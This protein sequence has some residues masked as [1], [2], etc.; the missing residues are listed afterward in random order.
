MTHF[1]YASTTDADM[2]YLAGKRIADPFFYI[3]TDKTK[4]V[5]LNNLEI[6]AFREQGS[7]EVTALPLEPFL[8]D[9][10]SIKGNEP[11]SHALAL[12]V[13]KKYGLT[14][15]PVTVSK[16]FPLDMADYL[17][18]HGATLA[19]ADPFLPER[20][21]KT[22]HEVASIRESVKRT[23]AA[24]MRIEEILF[25]G[26]IA[27]DEILY[28]GVPLT[29]EFLKRE[30]E[31]VF[32]DVGMENSEGIIISSGKQAAMPHHEGSGVI[33]PH[34]TI[35]CDIFPRSKETGLPERLPERSSQ[36]GRS[37]SGYFADVTRTYIKG[38]SSPELE[39]MYAA[40]KD[41]QDA[42]FAV[43][44][45]GV[46]AEAVYDAAAKSITDAGFHA[47]GAVGFIHGLGH[48]VGLEVHE[49]P[50]VGA[51]STDILHAGNVITVEPGLYYPALGGVRLEDTVLITETG[52]ENLT[53]YPREFLIV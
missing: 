17:R 42:A 31:R 47:G 9:A 51:H 5:I 53:D 13:L 11:L 40:V 1:H 38:A 52:Y 44:R 37:Q 22:K 39:K 21:L 4:E 30:V 15:T 6:G 43:L 19:V 8:A 12:L 49:A 26:E 25:A 41:A 36:A 27:D 34:T 45:S 50:R 16:H 28:E 29:S 20:A 46:R 10:R 24:F 2:R 32:V 35:V 7:A 48:G 3:E 23:G 18:A 33:C 14:K